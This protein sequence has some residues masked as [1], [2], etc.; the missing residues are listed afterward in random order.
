MGN[1]RKI[2]SSS[3]AGTVTRLLKIPQIAF[4]ILGLLF[5]IIMLTVNPP[6]R[7]AD[8]S[9]HFIKAYGIS[10]GH[11]LPEWKDKKAGTYFP[12]SF[13]DLMVKTG[14]NET[15]SKLEVEDITSSF[16]IPLKEP[17]KVFASYGYTGI[18]AYPPVPYIPSA[19]AIAVGRLFHLTPIVLLYAGRLCNLLAWL[20][21]VYLAISITP[22][23]KWT[24]FLLA[25]MPMTMNE[26]AS[27]AADSITIGLSF[28]AIAFFFKLSMD[29]SKQSIERKDI[30][31]L[32]VLAAVLAFAKPPYYLLVFLFV[33]IP[34]RKFKSKKEYLVV[35]AIMLLLVSFIVIPWNMALGETMTGRLPTISPG[36]QLQY[37]ATH[38]LSFFKVLITTIDNYKEEWIAEFTG[39][40]G[41]LEVA[42]PTWLVYAY[43]FMLISVAALDKDETK[44][45]AKEKAYSFVVM[46]SIFLCILAINYLTWT[47]LRN[48]TIE[49]FQSRYFIPIAPL[50]FLLLYNQ[51]IRYA[52]S[53][54]FYV[55]L[56]AF[57]TLAFTIAM[58]RITS[59]YF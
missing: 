54:Y 26:A 40:L 13:L 28:L 6:G 23:L 30:Y 49:G 22:V 36:D 32:L 12:R 25:L 39:K 35:F 55:F 5:G 58:L 11:V 56:F 33:L 15:G 10:R 4:L 41:W 34:V 47:P 24:F 51:K 53:R 20:A 14:A 52:K 7:T 50:L 8:E 29:Q 3:L 46:L 37:V 2:K 1:T 38:P 21:L 45:H 43:L 17:V 27:L 59:F 42:L 18:I 9:L 57:T 44:V 48:P 16:K 19:I 31:I